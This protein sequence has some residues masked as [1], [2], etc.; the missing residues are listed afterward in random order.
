MTAT[1]QWR[2][3]DGFSGYE[4]SDLGHVRSL[5][6]KAPKLLT[7]RADRHGYIRVRMWQCGRQYWRSVHSL[8]LIAFVGPKPSEHHQAAHYDGD[9]KNNR[10]PN[11]RWVTPLE[12]S[13]DKRRH[14]TMAL[15][16]SN[17]Q[18]ILRAEDVS[19]I[20]LH[21]K[22]PI[23]RNDPSWGYCTKVAK[24]YGVSLTT[25]TRIVKRRTWQHV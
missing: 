14:G 5:V 8:V 21:Y 16:E 4:V 10:L 3:V 2:S 6:R 12:N 15:G 7:E 17:G 1:Q 19:H 18:S 9:I 22:T 24:T 20:R 23:S 25:I 11:L 13:D